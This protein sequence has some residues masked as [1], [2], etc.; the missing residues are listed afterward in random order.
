MTFRCDKKI[1]APMMETFQ[2]NFPNIKELLTIINEM[3][4]IDH[5]DANIEVEMLQKYNQ[6]RTQHPAFSSLQPFNSLNDALTKVRTICLK[7]INIAPNNSQS[8]DP[9]GE[10]ALIWY[11]HAVTM[12]TLQKTDPHHMYDAITPCEIGFK[13]ISETIKSHKFKESDNYYRIMSQL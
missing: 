9:A 11:L 8:S 3:R 2:E 4:D 13:K 7:Q 6:I 12:R 10:Y 5:F 1:R